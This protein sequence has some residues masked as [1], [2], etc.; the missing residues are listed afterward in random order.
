[1]P[2]F[3]PQEEEVMGSLGAEREHQG[4]AWSEMDVKR[5]AR[6]GSTLWATYGQRRLAIFFL[7]ALLAVSA[8]IHAYLHPTE[9]R[10]SVSFYVAGD[11]VQAGT[12]NP[13]A[14]L[15]RSPSAARLAH[16][17]TSTAM[18]EHLITRFSLYAYYGIDTAGANHYIEGIKTLQDHLFVRSIDANSLSIEVTALDAELA[19][20]MANGVFEELQRKADQEAVSNL[21]LTIRLYERVIKGN[22]VK[23]QGQLV[24]LNG[25]IKEFKELLNG[26]GQQGG[27]RSERLNEL[28]QQL[29]S[30][31]T[32]VAS[33]NDELLELQQNQEVSLALLHQEN[34]PHVH[35][36]RRAMPDE[37]RSRKF[38][39]AMFGGGAFVLGILLGLALVTLWFWHGEEFLAYFNSSRPHYHAN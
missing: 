7:A 6:S 2:L 24:Q 9:C 35:L 27:M 37:Q 29:S 21:E 12:T 31:V 5:Y 17:A 38:K 11:Q 22:Q 20:A 8:A 30:L 28:D 23:A 14:Q 15:E 39:A 10:S 26:H 32:Q 16:E 13:W 3:E 33:A 34:I 18:M 4:R 36:I 25:V 1:M 19:A